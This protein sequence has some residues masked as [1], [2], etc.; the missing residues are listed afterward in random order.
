MKTCKHCRKKFKPSGRKLYC[1]KKCKEEYRNDFL[2]GK[3][4]ESI[5]LKENDFSMGRRKYSDKIISYD[6]SPT[7]EIYI[8]LAKRPLMKN[9]EG[10]GFQGVLAQS[11]NRELVQCAECGKW[12]KQLTHHHL[13]RHGLT[14]KTYKEKYGLNKTTSLVSDSESIRKANLMNENN[15]FK[16]S[17][18]KEQLYE[19]YKKGNQKRASG[20]AGYKRSRELENLHGTCPEQLKAEIVDY[21]ERFHRLPTVGGNYRQLSKMTT[22]RNRF[23]SFNNAFKACGLPIRRKL[24]GQLIEY[25]FP[26][27]SIFHTIN[28]KGYEELY[29]M[30]LSKC[31]I[32]NA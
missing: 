31:P 8:G 23:G 29:A 21:I 26:D 18:S 5:H 6:D 30:M 1:N 10:F 7:G 19:N 2:V 15:M 3:K 13:K 32:L 25:V 20:K 14:N 4:L 12:Y 27:K 28:G 11:V 24:S 22:I 17:R 9:K 16:K